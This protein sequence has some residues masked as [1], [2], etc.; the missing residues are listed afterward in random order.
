VPDLI[1]AG[2][3]AKYLGGSI[4]TFALPMGL[5]IVVALALFFIYRRPHRLPALRYLTSA[6]VAAVA[7]PEAGDARRADTT[8]E[9]AS[10][11]VQER[12]AKSARTQ[13]DAVGEMTAADASSGAAGPV[14]DTA[15]IEGTEVAAEEPGPAGAGGPASEGA[16]G[17]GDE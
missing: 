1:D 9:A 6:H 13:A 17:E 14:S 4:M 8:S 16:A 5:F 12:L 10:S 15:T 3:P 11:L 7:T 2:G